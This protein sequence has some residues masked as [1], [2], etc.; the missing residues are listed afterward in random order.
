MAFSII[1]YI[2]AN[3]KVSLLIRPAISAAY[4][5]EMIKYSCAKL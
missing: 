1:C 3:M 4:E 2:N 5:S